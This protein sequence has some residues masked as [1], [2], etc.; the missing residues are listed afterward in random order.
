MYKP[1][2]TLMTSNACHLSNDV[3]CSACKCNHSYKPYQSAHFV[4]P[5]L[6]GLIVCQVLLQTYIFINTILEDAYHFYLCNSS[7][8]RK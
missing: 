8:N 1:C 2:A 5:T 4:I 6:V 3:Q 7:V